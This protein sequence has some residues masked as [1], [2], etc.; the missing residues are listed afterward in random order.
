MN[1]LLVHITP[2]LLAYKYIAVFGIAFIAAVI[3]PIP[4]GSVLMA[5][6]AFASQGYFNIF[7]VVTLSIVANIVGDNLSYYLAYRY[8]KK[9]LT[10]IGFRSVLE[11]P[12]FAA[13]EERFKKNPGLIVFVSRFEVLSTL[14]VNLL[15]GMGKISYSNYLVHE[16]VGSIAQV[17]MYAYIGYTFGDNWTFVSSIIGKFILIPLFI[18]IILVIFF[19]KNRSTTV[20]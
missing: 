16:V 3:V 1:F 4:S 6:A 18:I 9:T 20:Q 7:W 15:S 17:C 12:K 8:G 14:S 5:T 10:H 11:S 19:R 13:V 2:Y